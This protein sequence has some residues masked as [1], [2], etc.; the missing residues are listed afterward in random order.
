MRH[1]RTLALVL[2]VALSSVACA[3]DPATPTSPTTTTA[4]TSTETFTGTLAPGGSSFFSFSVVN[5]GA[6]SV[7]LASTTATRIGPAAAV[8]LA[9]GLGTPSG[10][11]CLTA[12]TLSVT[13]GLS[14]QITN[15]SASAGVYCVS[16][17]DAGVLASDIT[18]VVRI[19]HT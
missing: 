8:P 16:V 13:P 4:V 1:I 12:S 10:F 3:G 14:A 5:S 6:V 19:V 7:T 15:P 18:F 2:A 9:L 17:A 11:G